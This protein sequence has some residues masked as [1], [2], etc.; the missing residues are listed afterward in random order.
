MP[1]RAPVTRRLRVPPRLAAALPDWVA[2]HPRLAACGAIVAIVAS[3]ITGWLGGFRAAPDKPLPAY[4]VDATIT[5][6][7][8]HLRPQRAWL[9][10]KDPTG[11][12]A[13]TGGAI[14]VVELMAE[15]RT[16]RSSGS[17]VQALRLLDGS[18]AASQAGQTSQAGQAGQA[19]STEQADVDPVRQGRTPSL[20][21]LRDPSFGGIVHPGLPERVAATWDLRAPVPPQTSVRLRVIGR[22]W[23]ERDSLIA[24]SGWL[25]DRPVGELTLAVEDRRTPVP[26]LNAPT[27]DVPTGNVP[28]ANVPTRNV[29]TAS[30]PAANVPAAPVPPGGGAR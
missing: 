22:E 6:N 16:D 10:D 17:I 8:W 7:E 26:A 4:T 25:R 9:G 12:R 30:V 29:P 23:V 28:V 14:L 11:R 3:V 15:N 24:G 13:P 5:T 2:V 18:G 19:G 20:I 1:K 27:A 21:L